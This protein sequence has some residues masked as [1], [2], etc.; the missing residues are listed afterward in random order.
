[1]SEL[2]NDIRKWLLEE[3]SITDITSTRIWKYECRTIS[4]KI[5]GV[6]GA[7]ALVIDLLPGFD[8]NPM[9]SQQNG[10]LEV[11]YYASNTISAGKKTKNDAEDRC[12]DMY[13]TIDNKVLN[14]ISRETKT[15]TDFL[16]LGIFRN[17]E[18]LIQLDEEQEC[19][20]LIVNYEI[21]YLLT[22]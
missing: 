21:Q 8:N 14:R 19:P 6:S 11:R 17:G 18:P 20:F 15:L 7:R 5:F 9:S 10:I 2:I 13:Y 22:T 1:M 16:L 3:S 12:W 4:G